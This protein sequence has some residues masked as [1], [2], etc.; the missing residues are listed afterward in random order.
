MKFIEALQAE[1]MVFHNIFDRLE[2]MTP[3]LK[4]LAEL[5]V[6]ASLL[7]SVM[8]DHGMVEEE[9]LMGPLEHCLSQLGQTENMRAEHEAIDASLKLVQTVRN[10]ARAKKELLHVV[11]LSRQHFDREER[12][13]F[14]LAAKQLSAKTQAILSRKWE[15]RR[16][17]AAG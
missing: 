14:P 6:L 2:K 12:L 11:Q 5:R 13:I 15:E 3:R 4:T 8:E 9:L 7:D 10:V 17:Q 1:H 16:K